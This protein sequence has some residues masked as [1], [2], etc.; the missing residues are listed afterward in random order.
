MLPTKTN[1]KHLAIA[2]N[3]KL[4]KY[5]TRDEVKMILSDK[6]KSED[7]KSYFLTFLLWRTG[8][9]ISEALSIKVSDIDFSNHILI[10][11]T[12]KRNNHYRTIPL[13]ND[14]LGEIAIYINTNQLTR[15]D[16]LFK[17]TRKTAYN[18]IEKACNEAGYNDERCHPHTFRHSYAIN[19]ISQNTPI[20]IVQDLLGHADITKTL[21][22]TKILG[23]NASKFL[24]AVI[25]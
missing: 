24:D 19:L 9:R 13:Q 23:V 20:T 10:I 12:L 1:T 18:W 16:L 8:L 22:Y 4:P 6:L 2:M 21:I 14:L 11:K 3:S 17:V 25:F 7:Y 5:F 15:S